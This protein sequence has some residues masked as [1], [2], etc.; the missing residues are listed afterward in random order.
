MNSCT[1]RWILRLG[2][3]LNRKCA[4]LYRVW[5]SCACCACGVEE[6]VDERGAGGLALG[7]GQGFEGVG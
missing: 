5:A 2:P 7:V 6:G 1:T 4:L 3:C